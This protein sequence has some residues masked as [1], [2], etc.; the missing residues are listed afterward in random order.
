M[1]TLSL[2]HGEAFSPHFSFFLFFFL[3]LL[4]FPWL[5][6]ESTCSHEKR[7][8]GKA[9]DEK[10]YSIPVPS[11]NTWKE[12]ARHIWI[13]SVAL[14]WHQVFFS[15]IR[16]WK[17]QDVYGTSEPRVNSCHL[18]TWPHCHNWV[19]V[20]REVAQVIYE[21]EAKRFNPPPPLSH[22]LF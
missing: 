6:P 19:A 8:W 9:N 3:L 4:F 7:I 2:S 11:L 18:N 14:W 16:G 5:A 13:Q 10:V 17:L 12:R 21:S 20:V 1:R 15:Q 22:T